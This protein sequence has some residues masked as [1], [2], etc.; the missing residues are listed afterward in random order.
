MGLCS[1]PA[2]RKSPEALKHQR[3][4]AHTDQVSQALGGEPDLCE[5]PRFAD[6]SLIILVYSQG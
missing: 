1:P 2:H 3:P 6:A 5:G 4:G